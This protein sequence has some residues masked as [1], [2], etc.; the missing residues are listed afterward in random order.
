MTVKG[1]KIGH[2]RLSLLLK[3][4]KASGIVRAIYDYF[5]S[6]SMKKLAKNIDK[7]SK[8]YEKLYTKN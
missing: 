7:A 5:L 6:K 1:L 3:K 4:R 8:K 2:S